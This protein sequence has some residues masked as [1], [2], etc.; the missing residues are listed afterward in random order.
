MF[1]IDLSLLPAKS[2]KPAS[3]ATGT[4]AGLPV[5]TLGY[6]HAL[7][8]LHVGQ[9]TG[10]LAVALQSADAEAGTFAAV[11]DDAD[12]PAPV[13]FPTITSG[14]DNRIHLGLVRL[15][16]SQLE[17]WIRLNAVVATDV[18][19]FS[20]EVILLH[21]DDAARVANAL[22]AADDKAVVDFQL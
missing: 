22:E 12:T 11:N 2:H 18:V 9:A 3:W 20:A 19:E 8:L 7:V 1:H 17:R 4:H 15:D 6:S 5:D 16:R 10:G 14:N 13:E 21:P